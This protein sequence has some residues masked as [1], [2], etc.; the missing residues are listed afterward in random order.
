V[1]E[2]WAKDVVWRALWH[3]CPPILTLYTTDA[4][5]G[6]CYFYPVNTQSTKTLR[7]IKVQY[8]KSSLVVAASGLA[9]GGHAQNVF[10]T[11]NQTITPSSSAFN[12]DVTGDGT[13]DYDMVF[14]N[15]S[16]TSQKPQIYAYPA[17]G[18]SG[19]V[20][21]GTDDEV[22]LNSAA[23]D[24]NN[25]LPVLT[26]GT[27]V[28]GALASTLGGVLNDQGFFYQNWNQ[29]RWGDWGGPGGS[30]APSPVVGPITGYVGL[31]LPVAGS[32]GHYNY[33][34]AEFT[35]DET[36]STPTLELLNTTY[37]PV[38]DQPITITA[39]PEP[40]SIALLAAGATGLLALRRRRSL[41]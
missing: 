18:G 14:A 22:F 15:S 28:S 1:R 13:A 35:V 3:E 8:F 6:T 7:M 21:P 30:V 24:A 38:A 39:V 23:G 2:G 11:Y 20:G 9:V 25:T 36:L 32:P 19:G 17:S 5:N 40:A 33:G 27:V 10:I 34:Y 31:A 16:S 29:N 26:A 41:R 12:F 37:D 4:G